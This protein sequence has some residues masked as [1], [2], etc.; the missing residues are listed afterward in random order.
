MLLINLLP[1]ELRKKRGGTDFNPI[2]LAVAASVVLSLVPAG[3]WAWMKYVRLPA[4]RAVLA[5]QQALLAAKTA[6]A[7]A[8]EK[9]RAQISEFKAHR[10]LVIGLLAQKMYWARALDEFANA[11][12]G[13]WAG[14]E[15]CCTDLQIQPVGK[16]TGPAS[17][18]R[19]KKDSSVTFM[20]KGRY[21]LV[22]EERPKSGDYVKN[23]FNGIE[24]S[25]FWKN[26]GLQEKPEKTYR[27]DT[28]A[29]NEDVSR[30]TVE[31]NLDWQRVKT[32]ASA[33]TKGAK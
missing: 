19:G 22:G 1:P 10:D 13:P 27:G 18:A 3:T 30:V 11:I 4:A 32:I 28:P 6:E 9:L 23:F 8:V 12:A 7:E 21:K 25:S 5:E 29:W 24:L 33:P 14:F 15:V 20:M 31:F 17:S 16:S 26:Q 2:V